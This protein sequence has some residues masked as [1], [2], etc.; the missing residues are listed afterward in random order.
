MQALLVVGVDL[1]KFWILGLWHRL[2]A[3]QVIDLI[4]D[5]LVGHQPE[6]VSDEDEGCHEQRADE[7]A[8]WSSKVE[9]LQAVTNCSVI[10]I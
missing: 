3:G 4:K 6:V 1:R 7:E 10:C 8:G 5:C 9:Q 2:L